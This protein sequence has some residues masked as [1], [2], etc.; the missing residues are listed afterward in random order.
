MNTVEFMESCTVKL[1]G[2]IEQHRREK[3]A[4]P[5]GRVLQR[6]VEQKTS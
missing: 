3:E 5:P 4:V 2:R 1:R 6:Q